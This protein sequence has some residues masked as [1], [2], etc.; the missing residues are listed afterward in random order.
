[1]G[2]WC[3]CSLQIPYSDGIS[4]GELTHPY[5]GL[6]SLLSVSQSILISKNKQFANMNIFLIERKDNLKKKKSL[7]H[8]QINVTFRCFWFAITQLHLN[9]KARHICTTFGKGLTVYNVML[10]YLA[11]KFSIICTFQS[12][13]SALQMLKPH[14]NDGIDSYAVIQNRKWT[15]CSMRCFFSVLGRL[16][17]RA[18]YFSPQ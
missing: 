10:C 17:C 2:K 15:L 16:A 4:D 7:I 12:W 9:R 11:D 13:K 3:F 14:K 1:M 5:Q 18:G 8:W 6:L